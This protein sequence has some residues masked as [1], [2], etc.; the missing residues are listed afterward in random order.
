M[1]GPQPDTRTVG[2]PQAPAFGL[3]ARNFESSPPSSRRANSAMSIRSS[4]SQT[5]SPRSS[6]IT[7]TAESTSCCPGHIKQPKNSNPWPENS[8]YVD[9]AIRRQCLESVMVETRSGETSSLQQM[10]LNL[11]RSHATRVHRND[12]LIETRKA[13]LIAAGSIWD[14]A[15]LPRSRGI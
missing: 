1:R 2:Q 4:T 8:A 6:T 11:S 3:P 13:S 7:Q 9:S 5:S 15:C 14:R 10:T 12:L